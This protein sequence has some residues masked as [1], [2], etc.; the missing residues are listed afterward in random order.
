[1]LINVTA[2]L[3]AVEQNEEISAE[4]LVITEKSNSGL[5]PIKQ[6][7]TKYKESMRVRVGSFR[8]SIR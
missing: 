7:N 3:E 2:H 1:M 4:K 6:T 8:K 5:K